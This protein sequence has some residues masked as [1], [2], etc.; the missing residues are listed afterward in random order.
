MF[1]KIC[2]LILLDIL[3]V[4]LI[5]CA[6][7]DKT[8]P[9]LE[10]SPHGETS[11]RMGQII[12]AESGAT[13]D[14]DTLIVQLSLKSIIFIGEVHNNPT[15]HLIQIQIIQ[16]LMAE[17]DRM[18]LCMEFFPATKQAALDRYLSDR[19]SENAFLKNV[20]WKN[21]WGYDYSLYRPLMLLAKQNGIAVIAI[22]APPEVIKKVARK[23]LGNL[24]PG[25][26]AL[27]AQDIDLKQEAHRIYLQKVFEQHTHNE[28]KQFDYFYQ[29]QCS[30]EDT[31]AQN[32]A[33]NAKKHDG[34]FVVL[35]GKGHLVQ[36][37]GIPDRTFKRHPVPMATVLPFPLSEPIS[38]GPEIGDYLWFTDSYHHG[39]IPSQH[40]DRKGK[41]KKKE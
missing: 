11:F 35:A 23:G 26:R 16:A 25:E 9:T 4:T 40:P 30:W 21:T 24:D 7:V 2:T 22:N 39:S 14:F 38:I 31:M 19:L 15:H 29:A 10:V 17:S 3:F 33:A 28:L 27:L 32:V 34:I 37:F 6:Q 36:K 12:E 41:P 5:G 18:T 8:Q 1:V 20:D 13:L